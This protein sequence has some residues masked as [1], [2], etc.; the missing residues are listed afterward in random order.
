[1]PAAFDSAN[2]LHNILDIILSIINRL[3]YK[4]KMSEQIGEKMQNS[5]KLWR[6]NGIKSKPS[7]PIYFGAFH[8][9]I[10]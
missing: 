2:I 10:N 9:Y 4:T 3:R 8:N 7:I 6:Q 1:M 5:E